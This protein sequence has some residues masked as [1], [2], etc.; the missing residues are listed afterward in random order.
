M[1]KA[2]TKACAYVCVCETEKVII[3]ARVHDFNTNLPE[4]IEDTVRLMLQNTRF[5][6]VL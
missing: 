1:Y 3:S 4:D 6:S 5:L 2:T